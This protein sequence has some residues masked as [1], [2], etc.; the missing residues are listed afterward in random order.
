MDE[1]LDWF[2]AQLESHEY[3]IVALE[4]TGYPDANPQSSYENFES[5][6]DNQEECQD[7]E[8]L[9]NW[10][11]VDKAPTKLP[12]SRSMVMQ[13]SS[14][15]SFSHDAPAN[16]LS[17]RHIP[18][19]TSEVLQPRHPLTVSQPINFHKELDNL[20]STQDLIHGQ[21]GS[22]SKNPL[23]MIMVIKCLFI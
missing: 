16:V 20:N 2:S 15:T 5:Y 7:S 3:R 13:I 19:P 12:P 1:K 4:N 14:D 8:G 6:Q 9:Y 11:D 21:L 10:D 22:L 17:F 18:F 23:K